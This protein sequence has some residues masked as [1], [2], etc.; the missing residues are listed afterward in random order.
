M[1]TYSSQTFTGAPAAKSGEAAA[2]ISVNVK[3]D[4]TFFV[5]WAFSES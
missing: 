4:G 3:I 2:R 5:A 1:V